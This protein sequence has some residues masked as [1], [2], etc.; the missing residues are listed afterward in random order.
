VKK[1]FDFIS[2]ELNPTVFEW[3][4]HHFDYNWQNFVMAFFLINQC[5]NIISVQNDVMSIGQPSS[6]LFRFILDILVIVIVYSQI[7][8]FYFQ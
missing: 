3:S 7:N 1:Q 4:I 2:K 5:G 6:F 8:P